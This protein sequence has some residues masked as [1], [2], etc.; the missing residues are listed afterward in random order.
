M[1]LWLGTETHLFCF[2]KAWVSF[3]VKTQL[4]F[5]VEMRLWAL[6]TRTWYNIETQLLLGTEAQLSCFAKTQARE[7]WRDVV[8]E[9]KMQLSLCWSDADF[10]VETRISLCWRNTTH[11]HRRDTFFHLFREC[12]PRQ[13]KRRGLHFV[14]GMHPSNCWMWHGFRFVKGHRL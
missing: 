1:Q 6:Q 10:K 4:S 11:G 5:D 8:F 13:S 12:N 2:A 3:K 7:Y 9:V 14:E